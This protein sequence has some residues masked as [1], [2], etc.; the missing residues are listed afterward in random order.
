MAATKLEKAA[1]T[2][3]GKAAAQGYLEKLERE[4]DVHLN[5]CV[6]SSR[7]VYL[8]LPQDRYYT[9]KVYYLFCGMT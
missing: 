4:V 7:C 3:E 2:F 6:L 8:D 1:D 9:A 5:M